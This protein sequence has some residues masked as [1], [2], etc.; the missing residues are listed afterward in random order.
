VDVLIEI[1]EELQF[2]AV[3]S[4]G[5]G[6]QHVNKV[7]TKVELRFDVYGSKYLSEA[8]QFLVAVNLAAK[9]N[10]AGIL[11]LNADNERSQMAN[12]KAVTKRFINL[13]SAALTPAKR[14]IKTRKP[15]SIARKR[16]EQKRQQSEKKQSRAKIDVSKFG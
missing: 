9:I 10:N 8:Q 1:Q 7:A 16:L 6:G 15:R 5:K 12:K 2:K 4:G 13:I 3:K 11:V 14:R